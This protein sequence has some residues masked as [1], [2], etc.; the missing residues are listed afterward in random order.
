MQE[1]S[2]G[3]GRSVK[4]NLKNGHLYSVTVLASHSTSVHLLKM[5]YAVNVV[6]ALNHLRGSQQDHGIPSK[7]LLWEGSGGPVAVVLFLSADLPNIGRRG[8]GD[9][10][11]YFEQ[12]RVRT[13]CNLIRRV[14]GLLI[15]SCAATGQ[16][17]HRGRHKLS[18]WMHVCKGTGYKT[19][20]S[21][22]LFPCVHVMHSTVH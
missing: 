15:R 13:V 3:Q 7:P 18:A 21:K 10:R 2:H 8:Y 16:V 5:L 22:G 1:R 14:C 19:F 9:L 12:I 11:S 6:E 17:V 4:S 20:E